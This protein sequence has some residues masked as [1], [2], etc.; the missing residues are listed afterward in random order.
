MGP[1]AD[2]ATM[3]ALHMERRARPAFHRQHVDAKN[4]GGERTV[5]HLE[6][7]D[8]GARTSLLAVPTARIVVGGHGVLRTAWTDVGGVGVVRRSCL[9]KSVASSQILSHGHVSPLA[10]RARGPGGS[11]IV[12]ETAR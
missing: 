12:T 8:D 11:E 6:I 10:D 4:V 3:N 1:P 5:Y 9:G 2:H 7:D